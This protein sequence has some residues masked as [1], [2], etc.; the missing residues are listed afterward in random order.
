M[1]SEAG[2]H[3]GL[4]DQLDD[5]QL[6]GLDPVFQHERARL[7]EEVEYWRAQAGSG[8]PAPLDSEMPD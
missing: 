6:Q 7:M 4:T 5:I 3:T 8:T 1:T 2:S